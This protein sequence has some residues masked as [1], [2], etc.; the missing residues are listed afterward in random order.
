MY[1]VLGP[2]DQVKLLSLSGEAPPLVSLR[3]CM[4]SQVKLLPLCL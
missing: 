4:S 2:I 1:K 3:V